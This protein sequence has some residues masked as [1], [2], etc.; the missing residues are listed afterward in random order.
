MPRP[1][2]LTCVL[3]GETSL[4]L[5]CA[6]ILTGRGHVVTAIIS[7]DEL[8]PHGWPSFRDF[9]DGIHSID[10]RPD[11]LFSIANRFI[12]SEDQL[13]YPTLAAINYHD[14]PLPTYAG[15]NAPSWAIL[16]GESRHGVSWH[17]MEPGVDTGPILVQEHFAIDPIDTS[18]SLSWKCF[19][20]AL[21]SFGVLLD[22][23]ERGDLQGFPQDLSKRTVF[24]KTNRLPSQGIIRWSEPADSI[25]RLIGAAQFGAYPNDFG[26]AKVLLPGGELIVVGQA[27]AADSASSIP[28][29]TLI[30][31]DSSSITVVAGDGRCLSLSDLS[32]LDGNIARV[33]AALQGLRLPELSGAEQEILESMT[34]EGSAHEERLR[35]TF[36]WMP[37]PPAPSWCSALEIQYGWRVC[38]REFAYG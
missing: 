17:L 15:V 33:P 37:A 27:E 23:L 28:A 38:L 1:A 7:S 5:R 30:K 6:E 26:L 21:I 29:G 12:L 22:K 18:L 20:H 11:L 16:N 35:K 34:I 36:R 25:L 24:F 31:V 13:G 32:S 8:I 3:V 9:T 2:P 14:S 19:E 4:L 10:E